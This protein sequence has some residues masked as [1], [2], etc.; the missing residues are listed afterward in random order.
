MHSREMHQTVNSP[1]LTDGHTLDYQPVSSAAS[2][3]PHR[4]PGFQSLFPS[5]SLFHVHLAHE[6]G[7]P[8]SP[9]CHFIWWFHN[10]YPPSL[11]GRT[12]EHQL[13]AAIGS[14][15]PRKPS[16]AV[17]NHHS[18]ESLWHKHFPWAFCT[19]WAFSRA[20][21]S[22]SEMALPSV[23]FQI[24]GTQSHS[25]CSTISTLFFSQYVVVTPRTWQEELQDLVSG[26]ERVGADWTTSSSGE[27][28]EQFSQLCQLHENVISPTP[29]SIN[30]QLGAGVPFTA[31]GAS[32]TCTDQSELGECIQRCHNC[33]Y[34]T[35]PMN[36]FNKFELKTCL[37]EFDYMCNSYCCAP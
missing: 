18:P 14:S 16:S 27:A 2:A 30:P 33:L 7:A 6:L 37:T 32:E 13:K 28:V 24:R 17:C 1:S 5:I 21:T 20:S 22:S 8:G 10:I 3:A 4:G 11:S 9:G 26:K 35:F 19:G 31:I 15:K 25:K 34:F 29:Q 36:F 23:Y 12:K